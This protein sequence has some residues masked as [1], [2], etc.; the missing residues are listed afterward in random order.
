[1]TYLKPSSFAAF[2]HL[3]GSNRTGLKAL[4]R[5]MYWRLNSSGSFVQSTSLRDHLASASLSGHD[6]LRPAVE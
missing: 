1:M 3:A 5:P 4:A 2:A 6:S